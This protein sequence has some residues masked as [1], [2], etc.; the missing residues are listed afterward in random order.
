MPRCQRSMGRPRPPR[1]P[2]HTRGIPAPHLRPKCS[3]QPR[4]LKRRCLKMQLPAGWWL[5]HPVRQ[6]TP[7]ARM[8]RGIECRWPTL[9]ANTLR[10]TSRACMPRGPVWRRPPPGAHTLQGRSSPSQSLHRPDTTGRHREAA[11][12]AAT[13]SHLR[14]V[15]GAPQRTPSQKAKHACRPARP[16]KPHQQAGSL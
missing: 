8:P 4:P 11:T 14:H 1:R 13:A 7:S 2:H 3:K 10:L 16:E 9:W 12:I 5:L 15:S 6:T